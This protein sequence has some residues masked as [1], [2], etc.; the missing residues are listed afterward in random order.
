MLFLNSMLESLPCYT[1]EVN[2]IIGVKCL[3][4]LT[5]SNLNSPRINK[6]VPLFAC[7]SLQIHTVFSL[8]CTLT[9]TSYVQLFVLHRA[10]SVH[11]SDHGQK[12]NEKL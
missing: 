9:Y 1:D 5:P 3:K 2:D 7:V 6:L 12:N 8:S 11:P 10:C 4:F